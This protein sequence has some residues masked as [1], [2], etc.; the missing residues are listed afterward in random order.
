MSDNR[1]FDQLVN[2]N[3][4]IG[5]V[6]GVDKFLIKLSGL[7]PVNTH[8]LIMFEDGSKGYV[9]HVLPDYTLVFHMGRVPIRVGM[10]AVVQHDALVS[11]VGK[12][13]VGRIV[14]VS[15]EPLDGKGPIGADGVWPVFAQAPML[16]KRELLDTQLETGV[17][18]VD[19]LFP[20]VK[21]QRIAILG[22]NKSGKTTLG[23]QT[24]INQR[25]TD[26]I[27][28]YVLIAKR[29]SDID[30]LVTQMQANNSL[31]KAVIVVSTMSDSLVMSFLAPYVGCSI[32]E[33][34][35]QIVGQDV[36]VI[37]DDLTSHAQIY[38]EMS[39]LSGVSPGRDSYPGDMF[40][41]HSQLLERAGKLAENH[42]TLTALPLVLTPGGD[43]T[44][45]LSTNLMSITDGQWILD[46]KTFRD[47]V[48]PALSVPLSV[49]R[50]GGRGQNK[51][52][53]VQSAQILQ[54]LSAYAT[55]E[56]YS[57]FG[58]EM[59][60]NLQRAVDRGHDLY[61]LFTQKPGETYSL[62][63][64]QLMLEV[65]LGLSP[66]E[67][68]DITAL[69]AN[70]SVYAEKLDPNDEKGFQAVSDKLKSAFLV[71]GNT[72]KLTPTKGQA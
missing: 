16:Y 34:L 50:V 52:Q 14:T 10:T 45:F 42:K 58:T 38:R 62:L 31:D 29:R 6:I 53:K 56:Q 8:A 30:D 64:Q 33:Y 11:Q 22:D 1:H 35:W 43:I 69:K 27:V 39:L 68:I 2:N 23:L 17:A 5:E 47:T 51:R 19:S 57:H 32:A 36:M 44:G 41:I 71:K 67:T 49:T 25:N 3:H 63:A 59:G 72:K 48:R 24:A 55:A 13:F 18:I 37:Y 20:L 7:Q 61:E 60:G 4:P 40:Y 21:G 46:M 15:G 54:A 70:A 12:G 66:E 28:V 9:H 26:M 65:F